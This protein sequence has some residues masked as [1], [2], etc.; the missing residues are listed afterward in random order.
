MAPR[1]LD[2]D[3]DLDQ[4]IFWRIF[5]IYYGESCRQPSMKRENRQQGYAL[6]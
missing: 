5:F 1:F 6:N 4:G 2:L 3:R